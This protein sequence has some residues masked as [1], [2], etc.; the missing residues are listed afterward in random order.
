MYVAVAHYVCILICE[1]E[2]EKGCEQWSHT[3]CFVIVIVIECHFLPPFFLK[4]GTLIFVLLG[5]I[6]KD[7]CLHSASTLGSLCLRSGFALAPLLRLEEKSIQN[8]MK[9]TST[10]LIRFSDESLF[11]CQFYTIKKC[12]NRV[13][14]SLE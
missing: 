1:M 5:I 14:V 10:T 13:E 8:G 11:L 12:R 9:K 2:C 7:D 3:N 4:S 6:I